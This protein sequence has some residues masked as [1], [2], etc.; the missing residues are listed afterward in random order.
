M[1]VDAPAGR[2]KG[3]R[4]DFHVQI[5]RRRGFARCVDHVFRPP[6]HIHE[7]LQKKHRLQVSISMR[8]LWLILFTYFLRI[9]D[10]LR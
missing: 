5:P 9:L 8:D 2:R 1:V 10:G 4:L 3:R 7:H 6:R